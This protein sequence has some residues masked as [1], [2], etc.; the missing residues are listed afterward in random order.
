MNVGLHAED[1]GPLRSQTENMCKLATLSISVEKLCCSPKVSKDRRSQVCRMVEHGTNEEGVQLKKQ[2]HVTHCLLSELRCQLCRS[3]LTLCSWQWSSSLKILSEKRQVYF[4]QLALQA[5][6]CFALLWVIDTYRH[7]AIHLL[8]WSKALLSM[9]FWAEGKA[10]KQAMSKIQ[11]STQCRL[12]G[13]VHKRKITCHDLRQGLSNQ[14]IA[15]P[16][17]QTKTWVP[18]IQMLSS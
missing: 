2:K 10:G 16:T 17:K 3:A 9:V 8:L 1:V 6:A 15:A 11:S 18:Q 5:F 7:A 13:S 12:R 4:R 14:L